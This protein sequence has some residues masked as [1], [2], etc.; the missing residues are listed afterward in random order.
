MA[1]GKSL[2]SLNFIL[3]ADI[4]QFQT[5]MKRAQTDLA[6]VGKKM[7]SIGKT[8]SIAVTLPLIGL[9]VAAIKAAS[10]AEEISSKFQVVFSNIST[11]ANKMADVLDKSYGLSAK[12]SRELLSDT[13]DL[14]TGFGFT[15]KSALKLSQE[16][17]KLAVDLASFSNF[18]GG[19]EG[20]S[21]ALTKALLGE[22]ESIKSLGISILEEDVKAK[23]LKNTFDGLTFESERQAKAFATLQLAQEQSKNALGDYSRTSESF[24]NQ[25]RELTQDLDDVAVAFG[26]VLL[27]VAKKV[28]EVIRNVIEWM[29][30]LDDSTKKIIAIVGG[31]A[32]AIGPV[33][34]V[35]GFLAT[36][37]IPGLVVAFGV[38][39]G[40]FISLAT[41]IMANPMGAL[42]TLLGLAAGAFIIFSGRTKDAEDAQWKLGDALKNVN[43]ELGQQIWNTL[44]SGFKRAGEGFVKLEGSVNNLKKNISKFSNEELKS[45]EL[46]LKD[47]IS[48]ASREAANA[49]DELS[50]SIINN[51]IDNYNDALK[52]VGNELKKFKTETE[53]VTKVLDAPKSFIN[54]DLTGFREVKDL[55]PDVTEEIELL[56]QEIENFDTSIPYIDNFVEALSNAEIV[57]KEQ[58]SNLQSTLKSGLEG[59][60]G[61]FAEGIGN[62]FTEDQDMEGF[63]KNILASIGGFLKQMGEALIVFAV[64]IE[65]FETWAIANPIAAIALGVAAI[66]AG[67]ILMNLASKGP[68]MATGG[69]IPPGFSNDS[70]PA[71]LSSGETVLPAPQA[72]PSFSND[73]NIT[74]HI[75]A[76][77]EKL[78]IILDRAKRM[79]GRLV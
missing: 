71:M 12:K 45:L 63:G 73:L 69:V 30:N 20:A 51:D 32:A 66:V 23:M 24:A 7:K 10:D 31:L 15:Q 49:T 54:W 1:G 75:E 59:L 28:L 17:Q 13:G 52:S 79:K 25:S 44:V 2:S 9:S 22:R 61:T 62:L 64:L 50:R 77:G 19:A 60:A 8:M 56:N 21:K 76:S 55:M 36:N 18:S 3:G 67:Q 42:I 39:K 35:L 16:V 74:G 72:L 53:S 43:K 11:E 68:E 33:L 34:L 46:F 37:I 38:L 5:K 65:S 6:K 29:K 41:T 14:L 57:A 4:K 48:N 78:L 47:K 70:Y 27:P 26:N 58:L 40:A